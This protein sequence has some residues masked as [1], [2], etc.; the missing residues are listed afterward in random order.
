MISVNDSV[1][2]TLTLNF[3]SLQAS[4]VGEYVCGASLIDSTDTII[5][6][7]NYT[8]SVQLPTPVVTTSLNTTGRIFESNDIQLLCIVTITPLDVNQTVN[9]SWFGPNGL[10]TMN[11]TRHDMSTR[12]INSA[13]FESSLTFTASLSDNGT[14]YYCTASVKLASD[15]NEL[16]VPTTARATN[17]TVI[18]E[19]VPLPMIS[20]NDVGIPVTG[21]SFQLVCTGTAPANVSSIAT[22]SVQWL[23]NGTVFTNDTLEG[24][25]VT[26]SGSMATL[27]FSSLNASTHERDDYTCVATLSI[28][29]VPTTETASI[30]HR[31]QTLTNP[32]VSIFSSQPVFAGQLY[33]LNCTVTIAAGDLNITWLDGSGN[34]LTEGNGISFNLIT[35]S[36]TVQGYNLIFNLL[37]YSDIGV[38]TCQARLTI[39]RGV[40]LLYGNGF[41]NTTVGIKIPLPQVSIFPDGNSPFIRG[42]IRTVNCS[43]VFTPPL[44]TNP[45]VSF[46]LF[47]DGAQVSFE[48]NSR[49][50][51]V[52]I[53][54]TGAL[55][56]QPLNFSDAG[57]YTCTATVKDSA[58]NPLI[59]S[60]SATDEYIATIP[61]IPVPNIIFTTTTGRSLGE[62]LTLN[63]TVDVLDNLL[64]FNCTVDVL[65]D[66]YNIS[67]NI[68]IVINGELI[69]STTRSGDTT[70]MT[71]I[72]SIRSSDAGDYQCIVNITQPDIDYEF[73]GVESTQVIL[74]LPTPSVIVEYNATGHLVDGELAEGQF[75]NIICIADISQYIDTSVSVTMS[76]RRNNTVLTNGS[77]FTISPPV[78]TNNQYTGVLRINSLRDE[79]D[80]GASYNCSVSVTPNTPFILAGNDNSSAATLTV[81]NF[82]INHV[83]IS[84]NIPSVPVAG[85]VFSLFCVIVVPPNFVENLTSVR[86]TYDLEASR[87][88]TSENNDA[89][90]VPVVRNGNI[91]TSV[92]T[93][94]P[95]KTTDARQ[96][97]CQ[98]T[99]LVFSTVDRTNRDLT[100]Q[101][102]P[103]SVSIVADPPTGPIYESTSYLL[104]CTATVNTTI[105]DTP[106]TASVVWTDP[107]G[108]V[109]P[110]NEARR[111]V[112]PPTGNSL[113]SMLLFQPIDTGLNN[114]GGTYICQMIINSGNSLIASSQPT[115]T[116]FA[117]T[118]ESLP[119][120]T[121]NFSSV[122]SVEVGQSLTITCTITTVEGLVVKPMI[123][124]FKIN[125]TDMEMLSN[126]NRPYSITTDDTGS[127][128][129]Y[130]LIL[131][132][133]RFEDAGMYTCMA[134]FN[135]TGFNNTNDPSTA[136]IDY[137]EASDVFSV[138]V[139]F[140]PILVTISKERD[141]TLYAGTP[142]F[143]KCDIMLNP[144]VTIPVT[145][146]NQWTRDGTN[147]PMGS[148]DATITEGLNMINT[149]HYNATLMFYPLDNADDSGVYTCNIEVTAPNSYM[150]FTNTSASANISITV[151]ECRDPN[152]HISVN[153]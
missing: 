27:S 39:D 124:F 93:L 136:T 3:F 101:I 92:L 32:I 134:E 97:Y 151:Y 127:V 40:D 66:L 10:I 106:V 68:S 103:P 112:I 25:T 50:I 111:Q 71:M 143:I 34:E 81:S 75:L 113:V 94:D 23:L 140:P 78:M 117:V 53:G 135:V 128:T 105:V 44:P 38:Y 79:L 51:A 76:W 60:S 110:T 37:D 85:D 62:S 141:D 88:V 65:D 146:T 24:V 125:D 142:F 139:D 13:N 28:P 18:V 56:F 114:D 145:V 148:S 98:A 67:V 89:R 52:Q 82:D 90:L 41:A 129:N 132:P 26:N 9:I 8:I 126:L 46:T 87:D 61:A 58:N 14:D 133:V 137:Q 70:A 45:N 2:Y 147:V 95:V 12:M 150:F 36:D 29:D 152:H 69:T 118:I 131:D 77:D 6:T 121:V 1:V 120:M 22:V 153:V 64:T 63:C 115:D 43:I 55:T 5:L 30:M 144:L 100:V 149:L 80:N 19:I 130:T 57:N 84:I 59:I 17:S 83:D 74:T 108:N 33:S 123:T 47:K 99:I 107:S 104:T 109:I 16:I 7:S 73:N 138:I 11:D 91:F 35:I 86:W 21:D 96:Y 102:S 31:L 54:T 42:T 122:G 116:T 4:Q 48:N 20:F 72:D 49:V 15:V 119:P